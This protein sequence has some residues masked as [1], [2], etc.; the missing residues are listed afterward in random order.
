MTVPRRVR[1]ALFVPATRPDRIPKALASGADAVIVDLEDSVV[2]ADKPRARGLLGAFLA[3]HEDAQVCVRINSVASQEHEKDLALC[4][5]PAVAAIVVPKA[6]AGEAV[7]RVATV[8]KPLWPLVES[9]QGVITLSELAHVDNVQ[10]LLLG[11]LDLMR[12]LGVPRDVAASERMLD[13]V[14]FRMVLY[15][16]VAEI[17]PPIDG[18]FPELGDSEGLYKSALNARSLGCSGKLCIHPRQVPAVNE[19]FRPSAADVEWAR[20]VLSAAESAGSGAFVFEGE[21]VDAPVLKMAR[22][23]IDQEVY[24]E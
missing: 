7:R 20:G 12:D 21:M 22:H 2:P 6:V 24:K 11:N 9:A 13:H 19:V 23:I 14:R 5:H 4:T 15:S 10:R 16:N 8:G 17:A 3:A 1:S 18:V